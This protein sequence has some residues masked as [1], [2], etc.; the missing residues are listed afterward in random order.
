[1]L[2]SPAIERWASVVTVRA[3]GSDGEAFD[4]VGVGAQRH[5]DGEVVTA[6]PQDELSYATLPAAEQLEAAAPLGDS[7]SLEQLRERTEDS[8]TRPAGSTALLDAR[9]PDGAAEP[10]ASQPQ[11]DTTDAGSD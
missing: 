10:E 3:S 5:A 1:M 7:E 4:A 8:T 9:I 6:R 2:A 11:A